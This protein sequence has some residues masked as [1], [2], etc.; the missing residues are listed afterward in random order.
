[1]RTEKATLLQGGLFLYA[2]TILFLAGCASTPQTSHLLSQPDSLPQHYEISNVAFFP[3]KEYQCGPAALATVYQNAGINISPDDLVSEIYLPSRKGSL[4]VEILASSRRHDRIAYRIEPDIRSLLTEVSA[5]NPVLVLQNLSLSWAPTWHYAVVVGFNLS[6]K[7]IVLRSG[8]EKRHVTSLGTFERTWARS[9]YWGIVVLPP[10]Q[11]P[12]TA[13]VNRYVKTIVNLEQSKHWQTAQTA[14]RTALARWPS[15]LLALI[16]LGNTSY[17][18]K[19]LHNAE[20]AF[21]DAVQHH[22]D[23]APAYNNLAQVL[24]E[25]GKIIEA[26]SYAETAVSLGGPQLEQSIAT[27]R[28]IDQQLQK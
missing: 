22:P 1:M 5:G 13:D 2:L 16:G 26:K 9:N 3:Q 14:Y 28:E 8:M 23:S 20:T 10:D 25:L 19:D 6:K 18:L 24:L 7:E 21:R 11:L 17:Q 27:L 15:N 12:V 4:Q